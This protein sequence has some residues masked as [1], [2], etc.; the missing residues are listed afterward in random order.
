[1][2]DTNVL[3]Y[4]SDPDAGRKALVANDLLQVLF[5]TRSG[6][7][8]TQVIVEY[9]DAST[10]RRALTSPRRVPGDA[11]DA[12]GRFLRNLP[13]LSVTE[14]IV[15][16]A[17]RIAQTHQMRI[18]DAQILATARAEGIQTILT[19][20]LQSAPVIEGVRY[21]DPFRRSFRPGSIGL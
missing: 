2:V 1:M 9:F 15:R 7:I 12:I 16:D 6:V 10:R 3:L 13:C 5:R 14:A 21:V 11:V 17:M 18:F 19:E 8:S 4:A 20:D